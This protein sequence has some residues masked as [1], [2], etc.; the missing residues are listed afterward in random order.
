MALI[1]RL[2][3]VLV[4][5]T[6]LSASIPA[7]VSA[8]EPSHAV[9]PLHINV[10]LEALLQDDSIQQDIKL[11]ETIDWLD[12]L[13][14]APSC[15]QVAVKD[16]VADCKMLDNPSKFAQNHPDLYLDDVQNEFAIKLAIC[17]ISGAQ[18]DRRAPAKCHGFL[19]T[20]K[21]CSKP[22]WPVWG[23][24]SERAVPDDVPCYP[25]TTSRDRDQCF[26]TLRSSSQY[27]TSYS[28]AHIRAMNV[29]HIS[30][31]T[32][33]KQM[34]LQVHKNLTQIVSHVVSS[35]HDAASELKVMDDQ[36]RSIFREH[37]ENIQ[38][39]MKEFMS[40][41]K[42]VQSQSQ[43]QFDETAKG[44]HNIRANLEQQALDDYNSHKDR[45][46]AHMGAVVERIDKTLE[47]AQT[48]AIARLTSKLKSFALN[49]TH[50]WSQHINQYDSQLQD[51]HEKTQLAM[52]AQHK[53]CSQGIDSMR[54]EIDQVR[55]EFNDL[56]AEAREAKREVT[57]WRNETKESFAEVT[58]GVAGFRASFGRMT[59]PSLFI[60][61]AWFF[62]IYLPGTAT[63][64]VVLLMM[65]VLY[66]LPI[67]PR[68]DFSWFIL[69]SLGVVNLRNSLAE[70][71]I[72]RREM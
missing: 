7:V 52:Q 69:H 60:F 66:Y 10:G 28:N 43:M 26:G 31:V 5:G 55:N 54:N 37:L 13:H 57:E 15:T 59:I 42:N 2:V 47:N 56:R 8:H 11:K 65:F 29:C 41:S 38:Q 24:W 51:Y 72:A 68:P 71:V 1:Y 12:R 40:F 67:A 16:L 39:S 61:L 33:E 32:I 14:S 50:S 20:T 63:S 58:A 30:R 19:P 21:A 44:L 22:S 34:A 36:R 35:V 9:Q 17:E 62:S 18:G 6:L 48:N 45:F 53:L 46:E 27:W 25:K 49:V 64:H 70:F 4:S 23:M 3:L